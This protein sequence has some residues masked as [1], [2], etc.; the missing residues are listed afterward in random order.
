MSHELR[1]PLAVI[2]LTT[3]NLLTFY[4]R[5]DEPRR[6]RMLEALHSQAALLSDLIED[7]LQV[8]R[9]DAGRTSSARAWVDLSQLVQLELEACRTLAQ[10]KAQH[11]SGE[12]QPEVQVWANAQQLRRA[13]G[14]LLSNAIKF[15]PVEGCIT[16]S[17][18][19]ETTGAGPR[20][21]VR[22]ADTGMGI[23]A[24]DLPHIFERFYR[25]HIEI[26]IPGTGLG[27]AIAQDLA[28]MQCGEITVVSTPGVGSTFTLALPLTQE[29]F[30]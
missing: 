16:C 11:L 2:T 26:D 7:V 22:V 9:I 8:S 12:C 28:K 1:T 23:P 18:S 17:C 25:S 10:Q 19:I 6:R 30:A 15:T 20:A 4:E 29:A 13:V 3:D 27:L 21:L 24:E 5:L 14:N